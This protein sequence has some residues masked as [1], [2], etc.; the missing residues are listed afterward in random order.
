MYPGLGFTL[1]GWLTPP[2]WLRDLGAE[3]ISQTHVTIPGPGGVPIVI[4]LGDPSAVQQVRD[5]LLGAR[6]SI[7][8][9]SS[10]ADRLARG[11]AQAPWGMIALATAAVVGAT[12]LLRGGKR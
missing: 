9:P 6:V 11:V 4:D 5:L 8:Q 1:P 12:L 10:P 7:G 2:K 3:M